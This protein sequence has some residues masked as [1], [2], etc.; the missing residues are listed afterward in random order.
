M[1]TL[2][3]GFILTSM[4]TAIIGYGD[5]LAWSL[6][7][8]AKG[9]LFL[10]FLLYFLY[11]LL[12]AYGWTLVLRI[13]GAKLP[14][15]R[16]IRIW[17]T[18]EACRWLPGSIWSYGARATQAAECGISH[19]VSGASLLLELC[20]SLVGW[21]TVAVSAAIIYRSELTTVARVVPLNIHRGTIICG[22][23]AFVVL[24]LA[25]GWVGRRG[26]FQ[27]RCMERLQTLSRLRPD[28]RLTGTLL[29][30]YVPMC[31]LNGLALYQVVLAVSTESTAPIVGVMGANAA[32][33]LIGFFAIFAPGGLVIREGALATLLAI[34]LPLEVALSIAVVWRM[35][36]IVEELLLVSALSLPLWATQATAWQPSSGE[37]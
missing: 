1:V 8:I 23:S 30:Y 17:I 34:W 9:R 25:C 11:F 5:R 21:A 29:L 12:N 3:A 4:V 36:Q 16:G 18:S 22:G 31:C 14:S 15:S 6:D 19:L 28:A 32:A 20:L 33:W 10:A 24:L 2:V 35:L 13:L 27:V 7:H 37:R 26:R